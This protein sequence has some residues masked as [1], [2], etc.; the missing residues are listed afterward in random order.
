MTVFEVTKGIL[1]HA[2]RFILIDQVMMND[3][4]QESQPSHYPT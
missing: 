2:I 4:Q 3:E 1:E